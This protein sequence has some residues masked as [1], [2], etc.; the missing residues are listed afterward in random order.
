[1][2]D[3]FRGDIDPGEAVKQ[4]QKAVLENVGGLVE[5]FISTHGAFDL[6]EAITDLSIVIKANRNNTKP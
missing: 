5:D 2:R 6:G 1:L 4:L 3:L